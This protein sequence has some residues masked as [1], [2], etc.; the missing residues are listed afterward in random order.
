VKLEDLIAGKAG[1]LNKSIPADSVFGKFKVPEKEKAGAAFV[2]GDNVIA[3][4][5]KK[6]NESGNN[7]FGAGVN[8]A[9]QGESQ[10][11]VAKNFMAAKDKL[12]ADHDGFVSKKELVNRMADRDIKGPEAAMVGT[13]L[14]N[15]AKIQNL[16]NDQFG[17]EMKGITES[18]IMALDKLPYDNKLRENVDNGYYNNL[19]KINSANYDKITLPQ[20]PS[21]IDYKDLQQGSAGDC[22]FMAVLTSLAQRQPQRI[23]DMIHDNKN[24]TYT[25][26]FPSGAV[27]INAP[28]QTELGLYGQGKAWVPVMEK[29]YAT[30]RNDK[31][32]IPHMNPYETI[33]M[34]STMVGRAIN[35]LT[36]HSRDTDIL[37]ITPREATREKLKQAVESNKLMVASNNKE[38]FGKNSLNLPD[39]HVYT[40]LDYNA[41]TDKVKLRNPWG[42]TEAGDKD[43]I[44]RDGVDD[45]IFELSMDEFYKI[46][47]SVSYEK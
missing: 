17:L 10:G 44:P 41:Q 27:T 15:K 40:I 39:G 34:G 29:A 19:S 31:W 7:P 24:G 4:T 30:L 14:Q 42:N 23:I 1:S 36:G 22:Y 32:I 6:I 18:D 8:S 37:K 28:T 3:K 46:Y 26:K 47:D 13:L 5:I 9:K 33:G 38:I 43:G 12:D 11:T 2:S 35:E 45:G 21:D 16:G 25:V 20:K